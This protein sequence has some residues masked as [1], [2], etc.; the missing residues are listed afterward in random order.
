[1]GSSGSNSHSEG[2]MPTHSS[3]RRFVLAAVIVLSAPIAMGALSQ[4]AL[5]NDEAGL[6]EIRLTMS[7]RDWQALKDHFELDTYYAADLSWGGLKVRNVGIRSRGNTTRNG[8]KPGLHV[9]F[10][11]YLS[12]QEFLGLK[13]LALDN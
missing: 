12:S 7:Q 4:D 3:A 6:Q 9:D 2:L 5:F 8:T 13:A 11:R 1:A 10:N